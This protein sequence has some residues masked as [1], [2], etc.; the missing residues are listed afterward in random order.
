MSALQ[1][2][3]T[4]F[5]EVVAA[6][7]EDTGLDP[8]YLELELTESLLMANTADAVEKVAAIRKMGVCVAIDDFGTGYSSLAYLR[9]LPIDRLKIDQSF[10]KELGGGPTIN[11]EGG[12]GAI[13]TAITSLATSLG[14]RVVA[15]GV[16][17]EAQRDYLIKIGCDT[18]QGYLFGRPM[19]ANFIEE[20]LRNSNE[21]GNSLT[22]AA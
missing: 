6:A 15:E 22:V 11:T 18:M 3:Q 7:L 13:I 5:L 2:Q 20:L 10:V 9:R 14:K 17:T 4:D 19:R 1:F 12:R 8:K 16:E 21:P